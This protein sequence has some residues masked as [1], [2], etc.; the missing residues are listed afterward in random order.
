MLELAILI[1]LLLLFINLRISRNYAYPPFLFTLV[2]LFILL[3]FYLVKSFEIIDIYPLSGEIIFFFVIGSFIFSL[4]GIA[5]SLLFIDKNSHS[6]HGSADKHFEINKYYDYALFLIPLIFLPMFIYKS[7]QIYLDS[8]L[9]NFFIG[10]RSEL[11][12]GEGDYG[13]LKYLITLAVFNSTFRFIQKTDSSRKRWLKILSLI[14]AV[15]YLIFSTSRTMFFFLVFTILGIKIFRSRINVKHLV[16]FGLLFLTVY[17]IFAL[18]L[19]K[20]G[21]INNPLVDNLSGIQEIFLQYL[22]GPLSA[23][24]KFYNEPSYLHFGENV[25]RFIYAVLHKIGIGNTPP[26]NLIQEF[27][28]VP[29]MTNVYTIYY[30]YILDYG[31]IGAFIFIFFIAFFHSFL[32]FKAKSEHPYY[33][34]F[35]AILIHPLVLSFFNDQYFSVLSLWLQYIVLNTLTFKLL[36][37]RSPKELGYIS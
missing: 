28:S 17:S 37:I 6:D 32:F 12:Y 5:C 30:T 18:L 15:I 35:Y 19:G 7:W 27:I 26:Q 20:G 24:D 25:F 4:G 36:I 3:S 1:H 21:S 31:L 29:F 33:L 22:L 34:Y 16:L 9:G 8:G 13:I 11:V 23:F 10:L 14:I 2:W